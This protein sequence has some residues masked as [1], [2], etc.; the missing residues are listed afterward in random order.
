MRFIVFTLTNSSIHEPGRFAALEAVLSGGSSG[1]AAG[2]NLEFTFRSTASRN[3]I[4]LPSRRF[5][6]RA[7]K[8]CATCN[9]IYEEV[10]CEEKKKRELH[11]R[12]VRF[13]AQTYRSALSLRGEPPDVYQQ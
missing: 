13:R 3:R 6:R 1:G 10:C 7:A 2:G 4:G 8:G 5:V 11:P 9:N 12:V